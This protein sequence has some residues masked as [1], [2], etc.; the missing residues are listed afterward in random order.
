[1]AVYPPTY[2][3]PYFSGGNYPSFA[4]TLTPGGR[5][6]GN[7]PFT[8]HF[9][10]TYRAEE[11]IMPTTFYEKLC[12]S[13]PKWA[14][15]PFPAGRKGFA[16]LLR[17][18][19]L[20]CTPEQVFTMAFYSLMLAMLVSVFVLTYFP[21]S[22]ILLGVSVSSPL[23]FGLAYFLF[24]LI[25]RRMDRMAVV[26]EA[27]LA[28]LYIVIS[29]R[30]SPSLEK[31]ISY[32]SKN[33]PE[34]IGREF[35]FL[36]WDVEMKTRTSM[37]DALVE[38]STRVKNWAPG[39]SDA[40]YLVANS[41]EEP[42]NKSRLAVLEKAMENAL[43]S[44]KSIMD[45][46]ARGLGMPVAVT[47][48]L[49]ILLPILGLVMAPMAS[50]FMEQAG[51]LPTLLV[52]VYDF[53]LPIFLFSVILLILSGRPATFSDIDTSGDPE[54]PAPGKFRLRGIG[55]IPINLLCIAIFTAM[56]FFA[57]SI[58][59]ST[60]GAVFL[61]SA[62]Q[63]MGVATGYTAI[64]TLPL[65]AG[66]GVS[67][68]LYYYL[69]NVQKVKSRKKIIEM[70][71]EFAASL[72]HLGNILEQGKPLE[73]A[74]EQSAKGLKGTHSAEFFTST[75][76]N[77]RQMGL[78]VKKAIFDPKY[79]SMSKLSSSLIRNI[80]GVI[81]ESSDSGPIVASQTT[82]S[83]SSYIRN[84]QNVQEKITD[85]LSD[86]VTSM[87]FQALVLVPLISAVI[88]GLTQMVT[89]ILLSLSKQVNELFAG[90]SEMG[91]A[92]S[93]FSSSLFKVGNVMQG[94]FLQLV[95]GFYTLI[96]LATLGF[97][98]AG[99]SNG[100]QD[101]IEIEMNVGKT[102]VIGTIIYSVIVVIIVTVF[103]GLT[104]QLI[105]GA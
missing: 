81:I 10:R 86:S 6:L 24:P 35:K 92:F 17:E 4:P 72:F 18:S 37:K 38:Y 1:M 99:L 16:K 41:V 78:P 19:L 63:G 31:A 14:E 73:E 60:G 61:P 83:I 42:S 94:S 32:A 89:N 30:V 76:I 53:F 87:S 77:I 80:L 100:M 48:A 82:L 70:E 95:V 3:N 46:F 88:V 9:Y 69:N 26:G 93:I 62:P 65:V 20:V 57:F 64:N 55:D 47:N 2:N 13:V 90:G 54:L 39:Y 79:G 105:G 33:V 8:S 85:S 25:K 98:V 36:M 91:G 23:L 34:P 66:I 59:M 44:T 84:I 101:K 56:G 43:E 12:M 22:G 5:L 71:R 7:D 68:G 21:Y 11:K 29:L 58:A 28:I 96:L 104:G 49:A 102:L 75:V 97:F 103:S 74:F 45:G 67:V 51:A 15:I 52:A 40:L 27:P 50:I